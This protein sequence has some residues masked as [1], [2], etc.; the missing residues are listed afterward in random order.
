M[1]DRLWLVSRP[2]ASDE[3]RAA[4]WTRHLQLGVLLTEFTTAMV[5][6]YV[7]VAERPHRF[8]LLTVGTAMMG[9]TP[10]LLALP[11]SRLARD[12]RGALVFYA[13]SVTVTVVISVVSVVDGGGDSP[14]RWLFVLTLAYSGLT[15]PPLGVALVGSLMIGGYVVVAATSP[16]FE[17]NDAVITGV[18]VLFTAFTAWAS[19]NHWDVNDQQLLLRERL[20][21]LADTDPL[22][23]LLNRRAFRDRLA[24]AANAA[25]AS[26]PVSLCLI[27]LDGFKRVNDTAGHGAG[28]ELLV[29]IAST[30]VGAA[31]ETDHVGR[32]GGDEFA[33]LLPG[34]DASHAGEIAARI[35]ARVVQTGRQHGVT[36]SIGIVTTDKPIGCNELL[37]TADG[38]MYEAKASGRSTV[39]Q[40]R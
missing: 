20:E 8:L 4:F 23:A 21:T 32:L 28:D 14:L 7:V 38:L 39:V 9:L 34:A 26:F 24:R 6:A 22:T 10:L 19:R 17:S 40:Q 33:V 11:M 3:H 12:H 18:L 16:P 29:Q 35:Q 13:W 30:L 2:L 5:L 1:S 36:A 37:T 25:Q 27:D 15:Y 31:R